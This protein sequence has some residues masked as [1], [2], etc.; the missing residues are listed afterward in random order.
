M[1]PRYNESTFSYFTTIGVK[2]IIRYTEDFVRRGSLHRSLYGVLTEV[3]AFK[4]KLKLI[5][6]LSHSLAYHAVQ[7][8]SNGR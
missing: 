6:T 8:S 1:E 2:K 4:L 3:C 5:V 7:G